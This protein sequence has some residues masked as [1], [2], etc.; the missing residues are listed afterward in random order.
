MLE[1]IEEP[2][3]IGGFLKLGFLFSEGVLIMKILLLM[4]LHGEPL[5]PENQALDTALIQ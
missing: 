1:D 2:D 4:A 3:L 5:F